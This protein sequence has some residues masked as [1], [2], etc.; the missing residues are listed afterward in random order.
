MTLAVVLEVSDLPIAGDHDVDS[1]ERWA[2]LEH[3][4]TALRLALARRL[5]SIAR[6]TDWI[7]LAQPL[8]SDRWPVEVESAW[9]DVSRLG[10]GRRSRR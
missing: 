6:W 2:E 5:G 7:H 9:A 3:L 10:R 4:E 1:E 8:S